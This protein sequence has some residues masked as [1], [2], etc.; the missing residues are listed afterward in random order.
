MAYV[1]LSCLHPQLKAILIDES[2]RHIRDATERAIFLRLVAALTDCQGTLIGFEPSA[3]AGR[4]PTE[5]RRTKRAPSAYNLFI[6]KCASS[7]AKGGEG[8]D[9]KTC[10]VAWRAAKVEKK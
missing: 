7:K 2:S 8:R 4:Q 1:T 10:A 9:F 6:R 3:G 5:G